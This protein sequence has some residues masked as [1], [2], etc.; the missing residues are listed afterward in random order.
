MKNGIKE[1]PI[2]S[3]TR[4]PTDLRT[5]STIWPNMDSTLEGPADDVAFGPEGE[6]RGREKGHDERKRGTRGKKTKRRDD[7]T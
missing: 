4:A 2:R 5:T 1:R 7:D 3:A 6:T